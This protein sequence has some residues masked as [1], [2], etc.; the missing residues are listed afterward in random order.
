MLTDPQYEPNTFN[1]LNTTDEALP[2]LSDWIDVFR[3]S[4]P[5]FK[6]AAEK[7]TQVEGSADKAE[8]FATRCA[9]SSHLP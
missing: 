6:E 5:T 7:D 3:T 4:V 2:K 9:F 1:Y 8:A